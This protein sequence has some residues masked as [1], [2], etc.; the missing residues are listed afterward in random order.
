MKAMNLTDSDIKYVIEEIPVKQWKK[1]FQMY[2]KEYGKIVKGRRPESLTDKEIFA[3]SYKNRNIPFVSTFVQSS[4]NKWL[5][6]IKQYRNKLENKG[7]PENAALFKA[8]P[9]SFF[10]NNIDL[11]FK[12]D[13]GSFS[14]DYIEKFKEAVAFF[15][16][17]VEEAGSVENDKNDDTEVVREETEELNR[18]NASLKQELENSRDIYNKERQEMLN[19]NE[20][21][22]NQ[23]IKMDAEYSDEKNKY[24]EACSKLEKLEVLSEYEDEKIEYQNDEL[25]YTSICQISKDPYTGKLWLNRL[26]DIEKGSIT[27]FIQIEGASIYFENRNRLYWNNGPDKEGTIAVWDWNAIPNRN[28]PSTD[29]VTTEYNNEISPIEIIYIPEISS[30]NDII[31]Y[32][33]NGLSFPIG[34]GRYLFA[35][36]EDAGQSVG[37]LCRNQQFDVVN[38]SAKLKNNI[39]SLPQYRIHVSDVLNLSGKYYCRQIN[40]GRPQSICKTKDPL[41]VTKELLLSRVTIPYLRQQG[42]NRKEAQSYQQILKSIPT[43]SIYE[44]IAETYACSLEEAKSNINA[45]IERAE[46]YLEDTDIDM[47]ILSKAIERSPKYTEQCKKLLT[48]EWE[49]ENKKRNEKVQN[50]IELKDRELRDKE[51]KLKLLELKCNEVQIE[52]KTIQNNIQI[53]ETLAKDVEQKVDEKIARAQ[54]NAADFICNSAFYFPLFKQEMGRNNQDSEL[55]NKPLLSINQGLIAE[56]FEEEISDIDAFIDGLATNLEAGGYTDRIAADM[57][58]M[59]TFCIGN[60]IPVICGSNGKAISDCVAAM[61]EMKNAN[62]VNVPIGEHINKELCE[63]VCNSGGHTIRITGLL[64]SFNSSAF[65]AL[66]DSAA[67]W[68]EHTAVIISI[69]GIEPSILP[70]NIWNK[71]IFIDGDIGM[72]HFATNQFTV[73][74]CSVNFNFICEKEKI[75]VAKNT[76]KLFAP[77]LSN[78]ARLIYMHYLAQTSSDMK[79]DWILLIQVIICAKTS[80]KEDQIKDLIKSANVDPQTEKLITKYLRSEIDDR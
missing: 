6:D 20:R 62:E 39:F 77:V 56:K 64:D 4:V 55:K 21:L 63:A 66:L 16:T 3:L 52:L 5:T 18:K 2:P 53:K 1:Y 57:A 27:R 19:E 15:G 61:F 68:P 71:A 17:S 43:D 69:D 42:L 33:C 24:N 38:E 34:Q 25:P 23:I 26:A 12:L 44:E 22:K 13:K 54:E 11:Y 36:K 31:K 14:A 76:L 80:G 37:V 46:A 32:L 79:L 78:I 47:D 48:K 67:K 35:F 30:V 41:A 70:T 10:G 40:L 8:I 51:E 72:E 7:I 65:N 28:D 50:D 75:K 73:F 49:E 74:K 60:K 59:I 9:L 29:Y 58:Q 45:F